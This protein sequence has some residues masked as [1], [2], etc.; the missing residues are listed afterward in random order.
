M[1]IVAAVTPAHILRQNARLSGTVEHALTRAVQLAYNKWK[2][3]W[4]E[5]EFVLKNPT[6]DDI[7]A[8]LASMAGR[9]VAFDVETDGNH[10]KECALRCVGFF[11]G[12]T[13]IIVP[14]LYRD[15]ERE[16][17][18]VMDRKGVTKME[19]H[20]VWKPYFK[21]EALGRVLK[22]MQDLLCGAPVLAQTSKQ[23]AAAKQ[24]PAKKAARVVKGA[25]KVKK[26]IGAP[27]DASPST[28]EE[29]QKKFS[30]SPKQAAFVYTQ[31]GQYDRLVMRAVLGLDIAAGD[32]GF[33]F[34]TIVAHHVIAPYL[35]HKLGFLAAL[36][37]EAPYYKASE[38]G[39]AW[40][41][42]TDDALWRYCLRGDTRV[43]L[44]DGSTRAVAELVRTRAKVNLLAT[45]ERG[46]II[47]SPIYDWHQNRKAGQTWR[48]IRTTATAKRGLVLT[49][50]H[51]VFI[52]GRG[53]LEAQDVAVGDIMLLPEREFSLR[54]KSLIAGTLLGDSVLRVSPKWRKNPRKATAASIDGGQMHAEYAAEKLRV[55]PGVL[56][57]GKPRQTPHGTFYTFAS[58]QF[59]QLR[60]W[61]QNYWDARGQR[62]ITGDVLALLRRD[63]AGLAWWFADD[64]CRQKG[65]RGRSDTICLNVQRYLREDQELVQCWLEQQFGRVWLD[66]A[67][68]LRFSVPA[69][70]TFATHVGPFLHPE[71]RYKLPGSEE[72][73]YTLEPAEFSVQPVMAEVTAND[74][75]A[76]KAATRSQ[77]LMAETRFCVSTAAGNFFTTE[78]LVKNCLRDVKAT[79]LAGE[80]M[81]QE[82]SEVYPN[83]ETV[84]L[85]DTWQEAQCERWK[86]IGIE[87]DRPTLRYFRHHYMSVRDKALAAMRE[88]LAE[89]GLKSDDENFKALLEKLMDKASVD[90]IDDPDG[91]G[92]TIEVFNPGS[93]IE[94]RMMLQGLKIPLNEVTATGQLSTAKELLTAARK[95][96]LQNKVPATDPRIAFLDYLF[97]W[98][99]SAKVVGTYLYPEVLRDGRVHP[100]FNVHVVPTGRLSSSGPNFQNQPAEIRGMF[101][102][103]E[104]HV[105][106]SMDWD[107]LE[108]RLGAFLSQ[109]P[110]FIEV[111]RKYDAKQGPK[112]HYV[113]MGAI[114]NL[115]PTKEAAEQN[116]GMY[117]AAKVFAYAVAY[118]AGEDTVFE[119]VR[120]ELPDMTWEDFQQAYANY[121]KTYPKLFAFQRDVVKQGTKRGY[122]DSGL[123]G[124]RIFFFEKAWGES[125]PEATAM[126]N[127]PYQSTGADVVGAAN[128]R[129]MERLVL[130]LR[131]GTHPT[132][133]LRKKGEKHGNVVQLFDEVC[134]QLAQVHDELVFE[135]PLRIADEFSAECKRIA[136]ELPKKLN[137]HGEWVELDWNLPVDI[138]H[139]RRWKPVNARCGSAIESTDAK[140]RKVVGKC[141]ELLEVELMKT[142]DEFERWEGECSHGHKKCIDVPYARAA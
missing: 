12:H 44:A 43:V 3:K 90:D 107:A 128:K 60:D 23:V 102:A 106:I 53:K 113:N 92:R 28:W 21:G 131:N 24:L 139:A 72:L 122:I 108:M 9:A 124:R 95:E 112:P 129:I 36:Y 27:A 109:D 99:E 49:P 10:P 82:I 41:A 26:S 79:W 29:A 22:A 136:E 89:V 68:V 66:T 15:G 117:R 130:P 101:V 59:A 104:G 30:R 132:M 141:R 69:T 7:V 58:L 88:L 37:T 2:P 142:T 70:K 80:Q 19:N 39:E 1:Q 16:D 103:R 97:A 114:F 48:C 46:N 121:K 134:E 62:R 96:L 78:G 74:E 81:R 45:D 115:P 138:H 63:P 32:T 31:N 137:E 47:S 86:D 42:S 135:V 73:P 111:F 50:D 75:Y 77:R 14:L 71:V 54:Q 33:T 119:Q 123:M 51:K 76:P 125:S 85:H 110:F 5:E 25:V 93:L 56:T 61:A 120:E 94:L 35:P 38:D 127:A 13:G 67:G 100:N 118:G 34:D 105:L 18:P 4:S 52:K 40:S 64:G 84:F 57:A 116:P 17:V 91:S 140:G 8:G 20:A 126:Q 83:A 11:D 133:K 65:T 98:R 87:L 6:A 55:L